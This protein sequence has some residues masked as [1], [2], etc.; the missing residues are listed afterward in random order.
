MAEKRK[1]NLTVETMNPQVIEMQYAV[2]GPIVQ[3]AAEIEKS[4]QEVR[5][6]G[7]LYYFLID[8]AH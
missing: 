5:G 2:R 3:K 7:I 6:F 4:L 8:F 1:A